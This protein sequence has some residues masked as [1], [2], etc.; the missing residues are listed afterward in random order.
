MASRRPA[1]RT[2]SSIALLDCD[3]SHERRGVETVEGMDGWF[4]NGL[5]KLIIAAAGHFVHQEQPDEV[6]R[7][8][9]E[10]LKK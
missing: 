5:E 6:N 2:W 4:P 10:F 7:V 9:L 1:C 3:Y 8:M